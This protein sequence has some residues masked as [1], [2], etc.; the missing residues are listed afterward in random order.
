MQKSRKGSRETIAGPWSRV[1]VPP[2]RMY[3]TISLS[4]SIGTKAPTRMD[5]GNTSGWAQN[6]WNTTMLTHHQPIRSHTPCSYHPKFC[7]WKLPWKPEFTSFECSHPFS[8][9]GPCNKPFSVPNSSVSVWPHCVLSIWTCV[10]LYLEQTDLNCAG[11]L[12][13]WISFK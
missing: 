10:S 5:N 11:P 13:L 6:S 2:Q 12:V 8:F 1:P 7:L 3:I 4:F 9:L